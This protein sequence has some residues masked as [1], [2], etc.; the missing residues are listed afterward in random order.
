MLLCCVIFYASVKCVHFEG[1]AERAMSGDRSD[2]DQYAFIVLDIGYF[3]SNIV[4][5]LAFP[6]FRD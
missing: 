3:Y 5:V 4:F 1:T 2:H 6:F